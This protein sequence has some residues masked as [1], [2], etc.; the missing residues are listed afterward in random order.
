MTTVSK[1]DN[2]VVGQPADSSVE[3]TLTYAQA[4]N[5]ALLLEMER[6][7]KVVL[8]GEDVGAFG[9]IYGHFRGLYERFGEDRVRDTPISEAGF[10]GLGSGAAISGMRPVVELMTVDFFGV[11][12]DQINYMAKVYFNSGGTRRVPLVILASIGNPLRQGATHSQTLYGLFAHL[13]GLKVVVPASP[14]DAKGLLSAAIA[15]D[16][17][18]VFLFHRGLL[19]LQGFAS[20]PNGDA[21]VP[22]ERYQ[23]ELGKLAV[24][25]PGKDLTVASVSFFVREVMRALPLL[26][27]EHIDAEVLDMRTLVPLDRAGLIESVRRTGRLLVVDEDYRSFGMSGEL[28]A[29]VAEAAHDALKAAP[30]RLARTDSPIPFSRGLEDAAVP[31]PTRIL[32]AARELMS[33][34]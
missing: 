9:G 10:V 6:D 20:E 33:R 16:N 26:E 29:S 27:E 24:R 17:P 3:R 15:D 7:P 22:A 4:I 31:T 2:R 30:I 1:S 8:M 13:P 32:R 5:E 11:A 21:V 12:M 14:Y 34:T 23:L 25:K 18:V 19:P 28:V